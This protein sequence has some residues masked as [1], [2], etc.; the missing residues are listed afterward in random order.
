[1]ASEAIA[2]AG[3]QDL[4]NY[5]PTQKEIRLVIGA[6]SLGTIFEWYDF[7]IYGTLA[8]AGIMGR[9]FLRPKIRLFRLY[10]PGL[11]LRLALV[12][13]QWARLYLDIWATNWVANIHFWSR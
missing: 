13:A 9:H 12:S 11:A 7:F 3:A 2:P 5:Q 10:W 8:A 6:S 4:D 1:M